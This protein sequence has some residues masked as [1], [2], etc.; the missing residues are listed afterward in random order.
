MRNTIHNRLTNN[1]INWEHYAHVL[2]A[3]QNH[4]GVVKI[5]P[6]VKTVIAYKIKDKWTFLNR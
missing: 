1:P 4:D 6:N 3:K 5:A 2:E